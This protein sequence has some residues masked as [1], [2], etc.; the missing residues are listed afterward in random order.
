MPTVPGSEGLIQ[1]DA[2]A[3]ANAQRIGFP[4][5]IT[6]TA[7]VGW[8]GRGWEGREGVRGEGRGRKGVGGG[9]EGRGREGKG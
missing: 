9:G 7:G 1:G 4:V 5:M 2:D 6:A 3:I 8:R